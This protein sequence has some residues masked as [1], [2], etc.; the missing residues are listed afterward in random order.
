[1]RTWQRK[2]LT[3]AVGGAIWTGTRAAGQTQVD[4]RTQSKSVDFTGAPSTRPVK[5]GT[6]TPS[7]CTPGDLF[8]NTSSPVGANLYAC[9]AA[10]TWALEGGGGVGGSFSIGLDGTVVG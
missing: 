9:V 7:L 3:L 6:T 8:F 2:M 5:T 4:L 1:M 10:N